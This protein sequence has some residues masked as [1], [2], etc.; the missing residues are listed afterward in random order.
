MKDFLIDEDGDLAFE[1]GDLKTG[2]S[3][4][5]NQGLL[6]ECEKGSFKEFPTTGVGAATF[7]EDEDLAGLLRETRRQFIEDGMTVNKI[8]IQDGKLMIDA[9][10]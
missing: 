4:R 6:I 5:Q 10:Y 8:F 3:D 2:D 1:N 9:E 7:L